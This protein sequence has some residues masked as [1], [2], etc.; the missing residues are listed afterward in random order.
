MLAFLVFSAVAFSTPAVKPVAF[1]WVGWSAAQ[2]V[3][4]WSPSG[5]LP[6]CGLPRFQ[7]G[8]TSVPAEAEADPIGCTVTFAADRWWQWRD[9]PGALCVL[10]L[11]EV[12]HLY[13]HAHAEGGVMDP[14]L[15]KFV[16]RAFGSC[17]RVPA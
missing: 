7:W 13:G 4:Y 8:T 17:D 9:R 10:I 1:D 6:A 2:A 12:G 11:H 14:G 5:D 3:R 15:E 16:S